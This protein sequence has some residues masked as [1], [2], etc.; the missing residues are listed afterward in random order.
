M[1][2]NPLNQ[3]SDSNVIA[4]V[5]ALETMTINQLKSLW[6]EW[7]DH[8]PSSTNREFLVGRLAYRAQELAYG[9]LQTK[10]KNQLN[11]SSK[12]ANSKNKKINMPPA[13]THLIREFQGEEHHVTVTKE[14]F[15][16]RG[17]LFKSLS[18][19]AREITGTRWSGPLFFGLKGK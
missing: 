18:P 13:G 7:F 4:R 19:I 11:N 6:L 3:A 5:A 1:S 15:T 14:G 12:T 17:R 8:Q 2:T 16:Y 10:A 9:G